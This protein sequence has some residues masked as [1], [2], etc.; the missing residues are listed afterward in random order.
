V[1]CRVSVGFIA[2]GFLL[3]AEVT[4]GVWLRRLTIR[5]YV[6]SRDPVARTVYI[7]MPSCRFSS[8]EEG[9]QCLLL[10][11]LIPRA[12][13]STRHQITIEAPTGIVLEVARDFDMRSI[14][15]ARAIF[16]CGPSYS[17]RKCSQQHD[18]RD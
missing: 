5:E 15:M 9:M 18:R 10:D 4:L 3:V 11:K 17:A 14:W 6:A 12:D 16:G 8:L 2:L 7:L 13:V 1:A